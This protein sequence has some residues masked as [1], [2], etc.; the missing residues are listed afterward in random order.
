V[1]AV[2]PHML[3]NG[4]E[5]RS[6]PAFDNPRFPPLDPL[7]GARCHHQLY[8][9]AQ[10][11][12]TG[13]V[14]VPLLW[15]RQRQTI[16]S[17]ESAQII[18]MFNGAFDALTGNRDDYYPQPLR[19]RIDRINAFVYAYVNN[20]VYRCGFA[21]TQQAYARAYRRLFRALDWLEDHLTRNRYLADARITEAD[22]RL[23]TTL[24]RFDAVYYGHFK[25]NR[26]RIDDYPALGGYLRE[27]YQYPGVAG[28]V[29]M[30][31]IKAHYYY[32]HRQINPEGIV[33]LGP[34]LDFSAPH[35]RGHL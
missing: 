28:T 34:R 32:S 30:N 3:D 16:V 18:R 24:V 5:Y 35:G 33:P 8:T 15:D 2:H 7:F 29:D 25:A 19:A 21:T 22:W 23:F 9:R 4:W 17:N 14:T 12:Y 31:H 20:G 13:R 11:D 27:L 26:Q 10:P 1:T 6:D